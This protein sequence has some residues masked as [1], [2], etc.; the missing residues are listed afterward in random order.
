MRAHQFQLS[1]S[2]FLFE[3]AEQTELKV[4]KKHKNHSNQTS[5]WQVAVRSDLL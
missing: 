4:L 2:F 1:E 3:F 5:R